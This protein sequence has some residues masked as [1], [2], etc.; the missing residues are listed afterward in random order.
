MPGISGSRGRP[1][2]RPMG[3]RSGRSSQSKSTTISTIQPMASSSNKKKANAS[4]S[5]TGPMPIKSGGISPRSRSN[6][7]SKKDK[8]LGIISSDR[9]IR[10][11]GNL[12]SSFDGSNKNRSSS[13]TV[14][15][16]SSSGGRISPKSGRS[17]EF[18]SGIN[19]GS[20]ISL[21]S[22]TK[23]RQ[24]PK[25]LSPRLDDL[26]P[27]SDSSKPRS[28]INGLKPVSGKLRPSPKN[29][30]SLK[31]SSSLGRGSSLSPRDP[32]PPTKSKRPTK[33]NSSS[34]GRPSGKPR[35]G[36]PNHRGRPLKKTSSEEAFEEES[37][38]EEEEE[39]EEEEE[40]E[41]E[42]EVESSSNN[43]GI[44]RRPPPKTKN[45]SLLS[46]I[47]KDISDSDDEEEQGQET[48]VD[49]NKN[50]NPP[51]PSRPPPRNRNVKSESTRNKPKHTVPPLDT[52]LFDIA[53]EEHEEQQRKKKQQLKQPSRPNRPSKNTKTRPPLK[54]KKSLLQQIAA[55]VTDDDDEADDVTASVEPTRPDDIKQTKYGTVQIS[56]RSKRA[57]SKL[58]QIA[59]EVDD[60]EGTFRE[61]LEPSKPSGKKSRGKRPTSQAIELTT[62]EDSMV[63]K[64]IRAA[65]KGQIKK[66]HKYLRD[67][68]DVNGTD[69]H[70]WTAL[71]WAS[72]KGD[73][74]IIEKLI[75]N[76]ADVNC[77]DHLNGWTPLH[78]TAIN[79]QPEAASYLI[80]QGGQID[81]VDKYGDIPKHCVRLGRR[82][83]NAL[84]D[85]LSK[86]KP[87]IDEIDSGSDYDDED[88]FEG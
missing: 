33:D 41:E 69:R 8:P 60:E 24:K 37:E 46:N 73:I 58:Q 18:N 1:S 36:R 78:L 56:P 52:S 63:N 38:E 42:E 28:P 80:E 34:K 79:H 50:S 15:L 70:G 87:V 19:K 64:F 74:D 45:K 39:A 30:S 86:V 81:S 53:D 84:V 67:G 88:D 83:A 85:I 32:L 3:G 82:G 48:V 21:G 68:V 9:N 40:E 12:D 49:V 7:S 25:K 65:Y 5:K 72:S 14:S 51:K 26:S 13:S 54:K 35:G 11:S 6:K 59:H 16:S 43:R 4:F 62:S 17:M 76:E 77:A 71:H 57:T 31:L 61:D 47:S 44:P 29:S 20:A 55:D 2:G 27:R 66:I 22:S 23:R 75:F 10:N